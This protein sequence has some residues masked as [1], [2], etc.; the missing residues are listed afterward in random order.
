MLAERSEM[1]NKSFL[2]G[3]NPTGSEIYRIQQTIDHI[4]WLEKS[5]S[6][7]KIN[8]QQD[9]QK[10]YR[11]WNNL[12]RKVSVLPDSFFEKHIWMAD[13]NEGINKCLLVLNRTH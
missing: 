12:Q 7:K 2:I 4:R 6:K 8:V 3:G 10:I 11:T 9:V 5:V 1:A 13:I